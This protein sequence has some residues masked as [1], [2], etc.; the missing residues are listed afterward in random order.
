M[1]KGHTTSER[2]RKADVRWGRDEMNLADWPICVTKYQQ[3]RKEDGGKLDVVEYAI[4]RAGLP[5]Q[6]V[7]LLSPSE[8]GLPTPTDVDVL[9]GLL[10]LAERDN[11]SSDKVHF[12]PGDLMEVIQWPRSRIK[13]LRE[14]LRRLSHLRIEYYHCYYLVRFREEQDE[15]E[16]KKATSRQ[17]ELVDDVLYTGIIAEARLVTSRKCQRSMPD[18]TP[19]SYIQWTNDFDQQLKAGNITRLDLGLYFSLGRYGSKQLLRHLNKRWHAGKKATHYERDLDGLACGH[20][21]MKCCKSL[22]E[23]FHEFVKELEE[24]KYIVPVPLK[25]RYR[26][27]RKGVWRVGFDLHPSRI[28]T[29]ASKSDGKGTLRKQPEGS[30]QI[31]SL[32]VEYYRLRFGEERHRVTNSD[33]EYVVTFIDNCGSS[34]KL[35]AILPKLAKCTKDGWKGRDKH[36][37]AAGKYIDEVLKEHRADDIFRERKRQE[38]LLKQKENEQRKRTDAEDQRLL[39]QFRPVWKAMPESEMATL[40]EEY[41]QANVMYRQRSSARTLEDQCIR[42]VAYRHGGI[43]ESPLEKAK[44]IATETR[45][46]VRR[47]EPAVTSV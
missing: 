12:F 26:K 32:A 24:Q 47:G 11:F 3:P 2:T 39:E 42:E 43:E 1:P 21:G 6:K 46:R 41:C 23:S 10:E 9:I 28:R 8:V 7:K 34:E 13:R 45:E 17:K 37:A 5:D 44:S 29:A 18:A 30:D 25:Q 15:S 22:K 31:D 19:K 20:L 36:I 27:V 33:R 35:Q 4:K 16:E 40:R 14:S 38:D